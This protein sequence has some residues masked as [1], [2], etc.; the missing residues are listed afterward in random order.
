MVESLNELKNYDFKNINTI[1][2]TSGASTP[3][4]VVDEII[5]FL[6]SK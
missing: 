1:N 3:S 6:K 4:D 5:N 2:I